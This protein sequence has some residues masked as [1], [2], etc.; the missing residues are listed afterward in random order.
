MV[1]REAG[2]DGMDRLLREPEIRDISEQIESRGGRVSVTEIDALL[3][4]ALRKI[5]RR[6]VRE[7]PVHPFEEMMVAAHG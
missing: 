2:C 7:R 1:M 4:G 6:S 3:R 5:F